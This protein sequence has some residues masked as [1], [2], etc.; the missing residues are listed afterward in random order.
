MRNQDS[1]AVERPAVS[2]SVSQSGA[3]S[4]TH[5]IHMNEPSARN[6]ELREI[7]M[8]PK[9]SN[10]IMTDTKKKNTKKRRSGKVSCAPIDWKSNQSNSTRFPCRE[11][12]FL[13]H[14][15]HRLSSGFGVVRSSVRWFAAAACGVG[16][17]EARGSEQ[18]PLLTV[19]SPAMQP[20]ATHTH[21][22]T[23][24]RTDGA[25]QCPHAHR[26][27]PP[28]STLNHCRAFPCPPH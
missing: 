2:Q 10:N 3:A 1:A 27:S 28:H 6:A 4:K 24:C 9:Q 11:C 13:K 19:T 20:A 22:F 7:V 5:S 12:A 21:M 18:S 8:I 25:T 16:C 26:M 15:T 14:A 17:A 23:G